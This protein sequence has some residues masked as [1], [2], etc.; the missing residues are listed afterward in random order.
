MY[1]FKILHKLSASVR[2]KWSSAGSPEHKGD[3]QAESDF[4]AA[5]TELI[6]MAAPRSKLLPLLCKQFVMRNA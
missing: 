4:Q 6:L 2:C 5:G 3:D 1:K